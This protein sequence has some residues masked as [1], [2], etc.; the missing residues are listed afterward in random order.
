VLKAILRR[1]HSSILLAAACAV[2]LI[3]GAIAS[4]TGDWGILAAL[5]SA[6]SFTCSA[7][8]AP[9]ATP[10]TVTGASPGGTT[11][12]YGAIQNAIDAAGRAGGGV[13]ALPAGTFMI[14][15]HLALKDNVE[16]TGVGPATVIKA[17]PAFLSSQAPGGGYPVITTAGASNATIAN[18]TADQSGVALNGNVLGRLSGYAVEARDSSNVVVDGVY[19]RHPFTYSIAVAGSTNFCVE[20]SNVLVGT[21]P[22]RY[23]QL[24]GIHVLDSNSGQVINN[25]VTSGDDGL[26]AHSIGA[27][28]FNVLYA[29]NTVHGGATDAGIDLAV[30]NFPIYGITVEDNDLCGSFWGIRTAFYDNRTGAVHDISVSGNFIHDLSQGGSSPAMQIGGTNGS[31]LIDNVVITGNEVCNAGPIALQQGSGNAVTGTTGC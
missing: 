19:V 17:G 5:M 6:S 8:G 15:G 12:D 7:Q 1:S 21:A 23:N 24:D 4:S 22:G 25:T 9:V 13:V 10:V 31:G 18:L 20:N 26:V 16:L 14:D 28:V 3:A 11:D 29:G 30:G 2:V 27:P